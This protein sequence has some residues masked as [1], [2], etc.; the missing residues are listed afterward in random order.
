MIRRP[1]RSTRTDT[2]FPYTTLFRSVRRRN[3]SGAE[4][5]EGLRLV[6]TERHDAAAGTEVVADAPG[7]DGAGVGV[8][9]AEAGDAA[10]EGRNR[11]ATCLLLARRR[12]HRVERV[13][14]G[15]DGAGVRFP[16]ANHPTLSAS[17]LDISAA[18]HVPA[19]VISAP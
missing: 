14:S 9:A 11:V 1:P 15:G 12:H 19:R 17:H 7:G 5:I 2:L 8:V 3:R 18:R 6:G 10:E 16:V 4:D 13:Q